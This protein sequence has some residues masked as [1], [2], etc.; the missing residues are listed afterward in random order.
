MISITYFQ[1]LQKFSEK[2]DLSGVEF[3]EADACR[4]ER[5]EHTH[6]YCYDKCFKLET[7]L[8]LEPI[9][10]ASNFKVFACTSTYQKLVSLGY[11]WLQLL[12]SIT[13]T[14]TGRQHFKM[15]YFTKC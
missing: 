4:F 15:Y 13:V 7:H 2:T 3:V 9:L 10:K 8:A 6:I 12:G 14:T 1:I 5:F 11:T